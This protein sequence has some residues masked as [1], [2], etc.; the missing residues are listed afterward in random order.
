MRRLACALTVLVLS[1]LICVPAFALDPSTLHNGS[2]GDEVRR[3]QQ[4]LI[5]LGF[6]KD[7]ADGIFGNRD[8]AE[9]N[10][11]AAKIAA[12]K[13]E[14]FLIHRLHTPNRQQYVTKVNSEMVN[15]TAV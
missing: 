8:L 3:L 5:A 7:Q 12:K 13:T 2:R 6:L 1:V 11:L 4:A 9:I 10:V 14:S 15:A